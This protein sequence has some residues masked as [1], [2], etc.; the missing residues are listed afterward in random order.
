MGKKFLL[1]AM[2]FLFFFAAIFTQNL[3]SQENIETNLNIC[4]TKEIENFL[5]QSKISFEIQDIAPPNAGNFPKNILVEIPADKNS[6]EDD[7]NKSGI[8]DVFFVFSQEFF[9]EKKEFIADFID[10]TYKKKLPYNCII[11]FTA[12][13]ESFPLPSAQAAKTATEELAKSIFS[14]ESA[15]A[16]L[17]RN[18]K[19][20]PPFIFTEGAGTISPQWI[21]QTL[22]KSCLQNQKPMGVKTSMLYIYKPQYYKNNRRLS[23]F[24]QNEIPA[25]EIPLG[26][27][28]KDANIL[29]DIQ[30]NLISARSQTW[31]KHYNFIPLGIYGL[32]LNEAQLTTVYLFFT[33]SVLFFIC[34]Y[35]FTYTGKNEAI[36]KDMSRT[37]FSIPAYIIITAAFLTLFQK[38]FFFTAENGVLYFGLKILPTVL[39]MFLLVFVQILFNFRISLSAN[40]FH[41]IILSALNVFI[42]SALDLSLMF[43]FIIE[44][45]IVFLFRKRKSLF[46]SIPCIFLMTIPLLWIAASVFVDI[47]QRKI[48]NLTD[49]TFFENLIFSFAIL[50]F[51]F[52]WIKL[53]LVSHIKEFKSSKKILFLQG[54]LVSIAGAGIICA[55]FFAA[56]KLV[57]GNISAPRKNQTQILENAEIHPAKFLWSKKAKFSIFENSLQIVPENGF[58]ILRCFATFESTDEL[59]FYECNFDYNFISE[60]KVSIEI[61][62]A[63]ENELKILFMSENELQLEAEIEL[64]MMNANGQLFH[65]TEKVRNEGKNANGI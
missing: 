14:S 22:K 57:Q 15:C 50:P 28:Q 33:I 9:L 17:I 16:I 32:W 49:T 8:S 48:S 36:L 43:I 34:F 13:N 52:Q 42:F 44:Y 53:I 3:F 1:K 65:F 51:I 40:R 62:D 12:D 4:T 55:I 21:V 60:N 11:S 20:A 56:A 61:P 59:P 5:T 25:A 63:P 47:D 30:D 39:A 29:S 64:F 31:N 2:C 38:L 18:E 26:H 35:S 6:K 24:L 19:N 46:F 45:L 10:S 23:A 54:I 27:A 37:W 41:G 58:K 7:T